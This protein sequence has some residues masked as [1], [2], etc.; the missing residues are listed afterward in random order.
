MKTKKIYNQTFKQVLISDLKLNDVF[1][2]SSNKPARLKS[3][4]GVESCGF[5]TATIAWTYGS[6]HKDGDVVRGIWENDKVWVLI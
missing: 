3:F 1:F 4:Q 5:R 6:D 2:N